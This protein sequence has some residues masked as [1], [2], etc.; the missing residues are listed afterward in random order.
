MTWVCLTSQW[1][2]DFKMDNIISKILQGYR[3]VCKIIINQTWPEKQYKVM[4]QA[5]LPVPCHDQQSRTWEQAACCGGT[6]RGP[7]SKRIRAA[8]FKT[9]YNKYNR[10]VIKKKKI[11]QPLYNPFNSTGEAGLKSRLL[12]TVQ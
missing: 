2:W 7:E 1:S 6:S 4:H 3:R 11:Q 5:Y 12:A 8:L 9:R 10:F